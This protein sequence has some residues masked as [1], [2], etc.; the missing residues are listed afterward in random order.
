[1]DI[2]LYDGPEW[3]QLLPLTYTR[4]IA[5]LRPGYFTLR[6]KWEL[7]SGR[8]TSLHCRD[9][10]QKKF[11]HKSKH[12]G[13]FI[14]SSV[15]ASKTL[16]QEI[17]TLS[18]AEALS[19]G[20]EI[21]AFRFDESIDLNQLPHLHLKQVSYS[22]AKLERP[23]DLFLTLDEAIKLDFEL[24]GGAQAKNCEVH[25]SQLIGDQIYIAE[26][27]VING[28]I[29]NSTFGPVII[30]KDAEVME[31]SLVRGP[32]ALGDHAT[33]KMGA[34]IYGASAFG[35]HC[36]IGGE[37]SN[38]MFQA[39]SNKGHDGFVGNSVIGAWCNFGADTNVS[40]LK[41]NYSEV[42]VWDYSSGDFINSK[43]QFCGL[44]MAD[45]SKTG[46]NTMLNTG[47]MV[48][49]SSNV[50]G[51]G[52]PPKFIPSFAWGG[53][54]GFEIYELDKAIETA[55]KVMGR[56]GIELT[57]EDTDIMSHIHNKASHFFR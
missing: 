33:L 13:I 48:G 39:Y 26:G 20:N 45:H 25:A 46:I 24:L 11:K 52:F 53:E 47:S 54:K 35:P 42:K 4:P 55:K 9:Y 23:W 1:M 18:H 38:S 12:Q 40:N 29:I 22:P 34:K 15:L 17:E 6:E 36:K 21:L 57:A 8:E 30:G 51:A 7:V 3:D 10:L 16:W 37:V 56:R 50:F 2:L 14:N 31:G 44:L 19:R 5:E 32:L 43:Q 28:A 41:N 49:V 27:A